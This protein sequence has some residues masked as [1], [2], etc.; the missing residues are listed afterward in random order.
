MTK[1]TY[2]FEVETPNIDANDIEIL[3]GILPYIKQ[4]FT[5]RKIFFVSALSK[6]DAI[7]ILQNYLITANIAGKIIEPFDVTSVPQQ[8]RNLDYKTVIY[9]DNARTL[10]FKRK[11]QPY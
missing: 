9:W 3:K 6:E 10:R 5:P 2:R 7:K 11:D 4:S 1:R 8:Y